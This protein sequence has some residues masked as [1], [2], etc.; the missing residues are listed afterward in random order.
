MADSRALTA[1]KPLVPGVLAGQFESIEQQHGAD[2]LGMWIFL[3]TEIMFFGGLFCGYAIYRYSFPEVF[4]KASHHLDVLFGAID[5]AVLLCSSLTMALGVR[6]MRLGQ[7]WLTIWLLLA[8]AAFGVGFLILHGI[9]YH[10]EWEAHLVPGAHFQFEGADPAKAQMFFWI[11]F[12]L[13]GLHSLHVLIGV[14]I[15]VGLA[16]LVFFKFINR[17][18]YMAVEIC[19]LYWHF[20]DIVWV[21]LFP[22]LY[23]AGA[24]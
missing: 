18:K 7:R 6:A 23:L 19:G 1:E 12:A 10:H 24:R 22:L 14:L 13:T 15:M 16:A 17:E 21:F 8:T 4:A 9:E 2:L 20:V 11:Y 3:A 5:T